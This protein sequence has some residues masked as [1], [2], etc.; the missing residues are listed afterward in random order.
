MILYISE[1]SV[2]V[3]LKPELDI[4]I[5][6]FRLKLTVDKAFFVK[7]SFKQIIFLIYIPFELSLT[8]N[9]S[10]FKLATILKIW[11]I[12][13][14]ITS[15]YQSLIILSSYVLTNNLYFSILRNHSSFDKLIVE[16]VTI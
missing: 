12:K 6:N 4:L 14:E 3:S 2:K 11:S 9:D 15:I 7:C 8:T 1:G 16:E 5:V 13:I 10:V